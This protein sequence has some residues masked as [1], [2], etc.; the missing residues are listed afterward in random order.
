MTSL[1]LN[2]NGE[3]FETIPQGAVLTA[4]GEAYNP[5]EALA[6]DEFRIVEKA[7]GMNKRTGK[8]ERNCYRAGK[9]NAATAALLNS[10]KANGLVNLYIES[11]G[12]SK[13]DR[14]TIAEDVREGRVPSRGKLI[15][16]VTRKGLACFVESVRQA[17]AQME[18]AKS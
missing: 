4:D 9:P 1:I 5:P 10:M 2:P 14:L 16:V 8:A 6:R 3:P 13:K 18:A 11:A 17:K 7:L 15:A 12:L